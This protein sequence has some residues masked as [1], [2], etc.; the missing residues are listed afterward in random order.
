MFANKAFLGVFLILMTFLSIFLINIIPSS[1]SEEGNKFEKEIDINLDFLEK[2]NKPIVLM[3]FGYVGCP[4]ICIPS[5]KQ[6]DE[7]YRKVDNEKVSVY[8]VNLL[9]TALPNSIDEYAK[10]FNKDFNGVYINKEQINK[11]VSKLNVL[12]KPSITNKNIIDHSGYL[13]L[14]QRIDGKYKQKFVYT[15]NPLDVDFITSDIN[16]LKF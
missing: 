11:V 10:M 9:A 7:I 14:F 8:F 2:E 1:F 3:F 15:S 16:K 4:D 13:H 6:I 5:L 12:Y